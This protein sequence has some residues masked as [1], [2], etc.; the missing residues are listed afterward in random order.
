MS[1]IPDFESGLWNAW[2]F[3]PYVIS[4]NVLLYVPSSRLIDRDVLKR[5]A[6][7]MKLHKTEKERLKYHILYGAQVVDGAGFEPAASAMPTLRSFQA[8]LPAHTLT[9]KGKLLSIFMKPHISR[10]TQ[11][12]PAFSLQT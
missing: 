7:D 6:A 11:S 10:F 1:L 2:L 12:P 4:C 9:I 8:D 5:A 3:M